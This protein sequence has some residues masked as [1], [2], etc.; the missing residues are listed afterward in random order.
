MQHDENMGFADK[1][2]PATHVAKFTGKIAIHAVKF[3]QVAKKDSG[4]KPDRIA[5]GR[6]RGRSGVANRA[7]NQVLTQD[8]RGMRKAGKE[9]AGG[10]SHQGTALLFYRA[11][12]WLFTSLRFSPYPK[13]EGGTDPQRGNCIVPAIRGYC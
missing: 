10:K 13:A 2:A 12:C 3:Q 9:S 8:K 5:A 1:P 7:T 11:Y 4:R 6:A